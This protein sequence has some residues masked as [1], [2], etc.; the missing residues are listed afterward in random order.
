MSICKSSLT[1]NLLDLNFRRIDKELFKSCPSKSI[2]VAVLEKTNLGTV[3]KLDAGWDDLGSWKSICDN[4]NKDN[5][6]NLLN[7]KLSKKM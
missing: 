4:S 2:D 3:I 1:N 6:Q 7:G 5:N